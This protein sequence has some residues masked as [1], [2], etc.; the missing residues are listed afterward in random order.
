MSV[1]QSHSS[2]VTPSSSLSEASGSPKILLILVTVSDAR[3]FDRTQE[4]LT[5]FHQATVQVT[6]SQLVLQIN[7]FLATIFGA[8]ALAWY[9][10]FSMSIGDSSLKS[11]HN[12]VCSALSRKITDNF[13]KG[14]HSKFLEN[15]ASPC[16]AVETPHIT[17]LYRLSRCCLR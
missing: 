4:F 13:F 10:P 16:S 8:A 3:C 14:A 12:C 9:V 6:S 15:Y 1:R 7:T 5:P 11:W 2:S 17:L